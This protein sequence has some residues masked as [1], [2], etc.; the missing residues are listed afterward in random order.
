MADLGAHVA[1]LGLDFYRGDK[2]PANYRDG[3]FVAEHGSW[4][5]SEK[6][7]YRVIYIRL[8]NGRAVAVEPF[9]SGWLDREND[10]AWG[11]PVDVINLP[12]GSLLVS[13]DYAD[14]IYRVTYRGE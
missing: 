14:A 7:G 10:T 13:D 3:L 8:E 9:I 6:A 2:F 1:P 5:R 12:D 11:R 4:N